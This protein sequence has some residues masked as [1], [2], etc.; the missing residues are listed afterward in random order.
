MNLL[1]NTTMINIRLGKSMLYGVRRP[2]K[3]NTYVPM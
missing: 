1:K 3:P 2:N